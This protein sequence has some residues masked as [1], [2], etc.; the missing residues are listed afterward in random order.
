MPSGLSCC[1]TAR[2]HQTVHAFGAGVASHLPSEE[3]ESRLGLALRT[4]SWATVFP[5]SDKVALRKQAKPRSF[6]RHVGEGW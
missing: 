2:S 3:G 5:A 4:C 1:F 6:G